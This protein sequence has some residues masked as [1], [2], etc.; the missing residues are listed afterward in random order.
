MADH[1]GAVAEIKRVLKPEGVA[2]VSVSRFFR[3]D[4]AR[5]VPKR[6][7]DQILSSFKVKEK[8]E[9]FIDRWAVI[10]LAG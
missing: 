3:K 5:A 2:Y 8:K 4:D 10:S 6:E 7:W 1:A 9:S